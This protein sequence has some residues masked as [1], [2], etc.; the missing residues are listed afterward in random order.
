MDERILTGFMLIVLSAISGGYGM[1]SLLVAYRTG[2]RAA[3]TGMALQGGLG[4]IASGIL[5]TLRR[6]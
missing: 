4:A 6:G 2:D 5:P 3:W 1:W